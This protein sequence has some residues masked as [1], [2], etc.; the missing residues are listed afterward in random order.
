MV[1]P[2]YSRDIEKWYTQKGGKIKIDSDDVWTYI[3]NDGREVSYPDGYPDFKSA[4]MVLEEVNIGKFIERGKDVDKAWS[5]SKIISRNADIN[6]H[7]DK[8]N[9]IIQAVS[10]DNH[11]LFRHRG[12]VSK[13]ID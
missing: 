4:G 12:G 1:T 3:A 13:F 2:P 5:Q 6:W 10:T 9:G 11:R 8:Y 7:H